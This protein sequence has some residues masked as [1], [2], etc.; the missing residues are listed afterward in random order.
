MCHGVQGGDAYP[1]TFREEQNNKNDLASHIYPRLRQIWLWLCLRSAAGGVRRAATLTDARA[2]LQMHEHTAT[3][4]QHRELI[5]FLTH[6]QKFISE[7]QRICSCKCDEKPLN[8]QISEANE[9]I[10]RNYTL[11]LSIWSDFK[12]LYISCHRDTCCLVRSSRAWS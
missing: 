2:Q 5:N 12:F 1:G 6:S 4:I 8:A 11:S 9:K 7:T 3:Y 10:F